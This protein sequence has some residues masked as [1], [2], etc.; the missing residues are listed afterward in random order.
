[1]FGQVAEMAEILS[2]RP[3][4]G[5]LSTGKDAARALNKVMHAKPELIPVSRTDGQGRV[6]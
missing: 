1:M 2:A 5:F 4:L 3:R 6:G